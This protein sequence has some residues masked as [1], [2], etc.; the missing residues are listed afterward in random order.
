MR[1][2]LQTKLNIFEAQNE[3]YLNQPHLSD[4]SFVYLLCLCAFSGK[5]NMVS[6]NQKETRVRVPAIV[7][8]YPRHSGATNEGMTNRPSIFA[9]LV[10]DPGEITVEGV[11]RPIKTAAGRGPGATL[12][13]Q[14]RIRGVQVGLVFD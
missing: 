9:Y 2:P 10:F 3:Y 12:G 5:A 11:A 6:C 14:A 4:A 1:I 7:F 13:V 8:D